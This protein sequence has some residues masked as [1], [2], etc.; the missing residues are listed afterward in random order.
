[1]NHKNNHLSIEELTDYVE[2]RLQPSEIQHI[3]VHLAS[4]CSACQ[5]DLNW[6]QETLSLMATDDWVDPPEEAVAVVQ[7][8]ARRL[9]KERQ[10]QKASEQPSLLNRLRSLFFP[11]RLVWGGIALAAV[12]LLL[13]VTGSFFEESSEVLTEVASESGEVL[14]EV[15]SES[16]EALTDLSASV[17][18]SVLNLVGQAKFKKG[19]LIISYDQSGVSLHF[20]EYIVT[21]LE[22]DTELS[23]VE[24][25]SS[26]DEKAHTISLFQ[27]LGQSS[28]TV[29]PTPSLKLSLQIETPVGVIVAEDSEF[30]VIVDSDGRTEVIVFSGEAKVTAQDIT[31]TVA[32]EQTLIVE[33]GQPPRISS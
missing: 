15:V 27:S 10:T 20:F 7:M 13:V 11:Q 21:Q 26:L 6:L 5:E 12:L 8:E 4:G 33:P 16:G 29:K 22:S 18:D 17:S 14:T 2:E 31:M 28:H 30:T 25:E 19:D 9:T 1:M 23:L 32:S 3:E 24:V